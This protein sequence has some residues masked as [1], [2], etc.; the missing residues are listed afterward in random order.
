[1]SKRYRIL[2]PQDLSKDTWF[3]VRQIW[4]KIEDFVSTE[5]WA[6][7]HDFVSTRSKQR[8]RILCPPDL[9]RDTWFCVHRDLSKRYRILCPPRSTCKPSAGIQT[10]RIGKI[11]DRLLSI[12]LLRQKIHV[13]VSISPYFFVIVWMLITFLEDSFRENVKGNFKSSCWDLFI[14]GVSLEKSPSNKK[15]VMCLVEIR[16]CILNGMSNRLL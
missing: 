13:F 16:D 12:Y 2:C 10:F 15:V 7:I 4:A 1:M 3:C 9:S 14:S 6:K 8:Y 5:I 11:G